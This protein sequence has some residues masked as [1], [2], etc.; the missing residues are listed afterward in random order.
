MAVA[1]RDPTPADV[2]RLA[3]SGIDELVLVDSPPEDASRASE[4]VS[5]VAAKWS[6]APH[7]GVRR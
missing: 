2:P 3:E 1:L 7:G 4:W 6:V 5:E